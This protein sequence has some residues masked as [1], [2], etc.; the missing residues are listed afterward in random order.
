MEEPTIRKLHP[1][2]YCNRCGKEVEPVVIPY[3]SGPHY[4]KGVCPDC[5]SFLYIIPKPKNEEKL[6]K[7]PNGCPT[8]DALEIYRCQVC[9]RHKDDLGRGHLETHHIDDDPTNNDRLNWL[10]VCVACH[11][12]IHWTRTYMKNHMES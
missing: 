1:K 2:N 7:R 9:L 10:V 11:K 12:L 6:A 8:P 5:E 3:E 4:A